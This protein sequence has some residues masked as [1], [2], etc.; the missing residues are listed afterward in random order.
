MKFG[1]FEVFLLDDGSFR[2]D[3]GAMF[4][5]I[6]KVMWSK[7]EPSDEN[8]RI[9]LHA[10]NLLVKTGKEVILIDNGLGGKW[11]D[12]RRNMFSVAEP[13]LLM[14]DLAR[15]DVRKEDITHVV[16]SH[17]HF[18]HAGGSTYIDAEGQLKVQFPNARFIM[19]KGEWDVAHSPTPRDRASYLP[20]NLIPLEEAGVIDFVEGDAKIVDG[21]RMRVTGGHTKHHTIIYVES[22][23]HT[24]VF[25][26]DLIPTASHLHIPFVMGYD[27]YPKDT[28]AFKEHYLP[29]AYDGKYLM[30]FEHGPRLKAG[31]LEKDEKGRWKVKKFDMEVVDYEAELNK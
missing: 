10:N 9:L 1:D 18:D 11:D 13:R 16:L 3:G 8:N 15:C 23:G 30:V 21:I 4:G 26:A 19:Q 14:T 29:E 22:G 5:I 31:H 20:E 7:M 25:N 17:L 6:P 27:L 12:K 24:M 2:L 28:M